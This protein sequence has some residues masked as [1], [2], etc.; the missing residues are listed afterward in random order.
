MAYDAT[1]PAPAEVHSVITSCGTLIEVNRNRKFVGNSFP[2]LMGNHH[3]L[4]RG[5]THHWNKRKN[6]SCT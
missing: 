3:T 6:V 4:I 5:R 1:S 2:S